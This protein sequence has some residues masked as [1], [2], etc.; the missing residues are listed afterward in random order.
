MEKN[1]PQPPATINVDLAFDPELRQRQADFDAAMATRPFKDEAGTVYRP[2]F[3]GEDN[4]MGAD[5]VPKYFD[6]KR[7]AHFE[8]TLGKPYEE[9]SV[10]ELADEL[11]YAE[12][13]DDK[14]KKED[15]S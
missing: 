14:T 8:E 7:E 11:A 1:T 12:L 4:F 3:P 9:Q 13:T 15:V 6:D 5:E 2:D 10:G